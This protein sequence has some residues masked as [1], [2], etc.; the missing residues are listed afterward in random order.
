MH[1]PECD[2]W[3]LAVLLFELLYLKRPFEKHVPTNMIHYLE[4]CHQNRLQSDNELQLHYCSSKT[5]HSFASSNTTDS[6][7]NIS[8]LS[9]DHGGTSSMFTTS[10]S[11]VGL[12]RFVSGSSSATSHG[13][14]SGFSSPVK[15]STSYRTF[16]SPGGSVDGM[17]P[18]NHHG[19]Q[20]TNSPG[21]TQGSN[22]VK[23]EKAGSQ[24]SSAGGSYLLSI[25]H[26]DKYS[27]SST[28]LSV[29]VEED[30]GTMDKLAG[31][32]LFPY[33]YSGDHWIVDEILPPAL[34]VTIPKTAAWM[35]TFTKECYSLLEG[36]FDIRPSHR[37]G[38]RNIESLLQHPWF[39][40]INW[41]DIEN[42]TVRRLTFL[43]LYDS[44]I[45]QLM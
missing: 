14:R 28:G 22:D 7:T 17:S 13:I 8:T 38:C 41:R 29:T 19:H 5:I 4:A 11:S 9:A 36:M 1:G 3:S 43:E 32:Q 24:N 18:L 10:T 45:L 37:L 27:S 12:D 21:R 44:N 33:Y 34:I 2:Y 42:K 39:R 15:S 31:Q 20:F 30:N 35:G 40:T 16:D 6:V 26:D 23:I 25:K